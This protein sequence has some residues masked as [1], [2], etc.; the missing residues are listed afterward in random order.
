MALPA[1]TA[2]LLAVKLWN[3]HA[4]HDSEQQ[5]ELASVDPQILGFLSAMR[6]G[7]RRREIPLNHR[8]FRLVSYSFELNWSVKSN[9]TTVPSC[10]RVQPALL[11]VVQLSVQ[12]EEAP[13][14]NTSRLT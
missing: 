13:F 8:S 2:Q 6:L 4:H 14:L 7:I 9:E 1:E 11:L 10:C 12:K 3:W 5:A